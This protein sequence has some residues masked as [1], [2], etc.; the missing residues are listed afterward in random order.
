ML[1]QTVVSDFATPWTVAHQAPLSMGFPRQEGWSRLSFPS[2][3]HLPERG[4]E[5]TS[6]T[7]PAW[8]GKFF[9]ARATLEALVLVDLLFNPHVIHFFLV[10]II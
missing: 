10:P 2:P 6:L 7:T 3:G 8:A 1:S 9:S 5:P 4:N